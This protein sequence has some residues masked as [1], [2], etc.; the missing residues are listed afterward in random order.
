MVPCPAS[1]DIKPRLMPWLNAMP[2]APPKTASGRNASE[3]TAPKNHGILG[4]LKTMR[5]TTVRI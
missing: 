2:N 3:K 4:M 1:F 5:R